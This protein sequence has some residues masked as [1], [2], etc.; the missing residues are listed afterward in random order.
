M[1]RYRKE[2]LIDRETIARRVQEMGRQITE[3]YSK[4]SLRPLVVISIL[5][6]AIPFTADLI[7]AIDRPLRLETMVASSYGS[8][9]VSSGKLNIKYRSFDDLSGC[10]VILVDDI[11]DSGHTLAAIKNTIADFH[12]ASVATCCFLSKPERREVEMA[13]DY[14]GLEVPDKF[15]IGYG[16][17]FDGQYRELPDIC[18]IVFEEEEK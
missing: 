5:K 12:P 13:V 9:T 15:V 14:L 11:I 8:G 10:D 2:I 6:G 17:D 1:E 4:K 3:D 18:A 7:R 16:L